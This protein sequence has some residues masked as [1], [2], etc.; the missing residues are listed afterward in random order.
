MSQLKVGDTV[1]QR[2]KEGTVIEVSPKHGIAIHWKT[3]FGWKGGH[4]ARYQPE[5][6]EKYH[7]RGEDVA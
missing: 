2:E 3:A 6:L 1:H 5:E 7:I 4:I